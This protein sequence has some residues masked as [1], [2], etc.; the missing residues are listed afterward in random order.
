[1]FILFLKN[2]ILLCSLIFTLPLPELRVWWFLW[3]QL[4]GPGVAE[5]SLQDWGLTSGRRVPTACFRD[6]NVSTWKFSEGIRCYSSQ[7]PGER[8]AAS[9]EWRAAR[10]AGSDLQ[11]GYSSSYWNILTWESGI[12]IEL[13]RNFWSFAYTHSLIILCYNAVADI[14]LLTKIGLW[15]PVLIEKFLGLSRIHVG[16]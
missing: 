2:Y 15:F 7:D 10:G 4:I 5:D 1:M 9:P 14:F 3:A 16:L 8:M 6:W 13:K 11:E 12:F